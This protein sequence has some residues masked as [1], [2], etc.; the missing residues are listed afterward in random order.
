VSQ[1]HEILIEI[2]S[3]TQ[4]VMRLASFMPAY[5]LASF[6]NTVSIAHKLAEM[7]LCSVDAHLR[8]IHPTNNSRK[9]KFCR[10]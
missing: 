4:V 7:L 2:E 10:I 6:A 8:P 9:K 3:E 5:T 1:E